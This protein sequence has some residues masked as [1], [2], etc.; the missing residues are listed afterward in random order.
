MACSKTGGMIGS[1]LV[2]DTSNTISQSVETTGMHIVKYGVYPVA[3]S[4]V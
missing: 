3:I 1:V 2:V 4:M